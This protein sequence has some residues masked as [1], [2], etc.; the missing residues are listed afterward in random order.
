MSVAESMRVFTPSSRARYEHPSPTTNRPSA[1]V[2]CTSHVRPGA[3]APWYN[4]NQTMR[5]RNATQ[6]SVGRLVYERNRCTDCLLV[7]SAHP[8]QRLCVQTTHLNAWLL[9]RR[10]GRQQ[11]RCSFL[12]GR[13]RQRVA[14]RAS[15]LFVS[16]AAMSQHTQLV[17]GQ[18]H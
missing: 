5:D 7:Q 2:L 9:Y 11:V 16:T 3:A 12:R 14:L 17:D 8:V 6:F 1:S 13:E 10:V 15:G 18:R 4:R